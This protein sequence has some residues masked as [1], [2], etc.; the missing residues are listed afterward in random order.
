M[1]KYKVN[2]RSPSLDEKDKQNRLY[3]FFHLHKISKP[4]KLI[5]GK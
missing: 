3:N 5:G 1:Q 2:L 4:A